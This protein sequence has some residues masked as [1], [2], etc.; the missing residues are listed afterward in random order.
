MAATLKPYLNAVRHTLTAAMCLENFE[1][2]IVERH[3]KP[4]VEVKTSKE[5]LLTPVVVSRNEKERVS[6]KN[7]LLTVRNFQHGILDQYRYKRDLLC[8]IN[9]W[10]SLLAAIVMQSGAFNANCLLV[11]TALSFRLSYNLQSCPNDQRTNGRDGSLTLSLV[12]A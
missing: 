2:Q 1:S 12:K 11:L 4:E 3:N 5:L 10:Y 8:L 7:S 6:V 9:S